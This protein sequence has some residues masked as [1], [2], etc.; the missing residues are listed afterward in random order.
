V[1]YITPV[2]GVILGFL[3]LKET[4]SWHEPVG[5]ALVILGVLLTQG[6]LRWPAGSARTP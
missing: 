6:R 4:L 5:A 1:T 3:V 2:I